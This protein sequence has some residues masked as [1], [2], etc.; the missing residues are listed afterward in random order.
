MSA[1][2]TEGKWSRSGSSQEDVHEDDRKMCH[3][4]DVHYIREY[5]KERLGKNGLY[6]L[7]APED[8]R[9]DREIVCLA[10]AET[11]TALQHASLLLRADK[12]VVMTAVSHSDYT[13][14]AVLRFASA[15]LRADRDIVLTAV[16]Q[17]WHELRFADETLRS[18][19]DIVL[20]AMRESHGFALG[21]AAPCLLADPIFLAALQEYTHDKIV[22][23]VSLLSGRSCLYVCKGITGAIHRENLITFTNKVAVVSHCARMLELSLSCEQRQQAELLKGTTPLSELGPFIS[24]WGLECGNVYTLQLTL[25]SCL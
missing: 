13:D 12:E 18:D 23:E 14:G 17:N 3:I 1:A 10:V 16:N 8:L 2:G 22:L 7:H 5:W 15:A 24:D 21:Y 20:A 19:K 11:P 6:L 9:N 4:G 25:S